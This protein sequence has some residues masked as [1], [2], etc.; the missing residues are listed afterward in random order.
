MI[1]FSYKVSCCVF[2][3]FVRWWATL[4]FVLEIWGRC[5]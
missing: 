4:H 2:D 1:T 3:S 5:D